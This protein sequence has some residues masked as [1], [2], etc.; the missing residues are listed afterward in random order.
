MS[1]SWR[2]RYTPWHLSIVMSSFFI[3]MRDGDRSM[4][5]HWP[6]GSTI[7]KCRQLHRL[8]ESPR[9]R[10]YGT[11]ETAWLMEVTGMGDADSDG[12]SALGCWGC[13]LHSQSTSRAVPCKLQS[14]CITW[15]SYWSPSTRFSNRLRYTLSNEALSPGSKNRGPRPADV[16]CQ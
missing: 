11:V 14:V 3:I 8:P 12:N 9:W 13:W 10:C 1:S 4:W 15:E 5:L 6:F 2:Q 7:V 16:F